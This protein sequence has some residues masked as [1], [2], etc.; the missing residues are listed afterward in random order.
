M[1]RFAPILILLASFTPLAT[2]QTQISD[3][4]ACHPEN[5]IAALNFQLASQFLIVVSAE[6][7]SARNLKFVIDTGATHS[8]IDAALADRLHLQRKSGKALSFDKF[9][10]IDWAELPELHLGPFHAEKIPVMV[11]HLSQ[12]S[13]FASN[14]DGIIG[15]DILCKNKKVVV[16]YQ[17]S[18]LSLEFDGTSIRQSVPSAFVVSATIQGLPVHLVVDT[19]FQGLLLYRDRLHKRLP[20]L[21]TVGDFVET[22]MGRLQGVR[23]SV[24]GIC[25]TGPEETASIFLIDGP[26]ESTMPDVDGFFGPASLHPH[27]LEFDFSRSLLT[28][29]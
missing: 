9:L 21:R 29:Q 5:C 11:V 8:L 22:K 2:A 23:V 25:L 14:I 10:S 13:Q 3:P 17:H 12:Y 26:P 1:L 7:A 4:P 15:L 27:R 28:V 6:V 20:H 18:I 19:G 24:P 16:D